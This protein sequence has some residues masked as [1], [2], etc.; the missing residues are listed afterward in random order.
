MTS[1]TGSSVTA[2]RNPVVSMENLGKCGRGLVANASRHLTD[3]VVVRF[4]QGSS[5]LHSMGDQIAVN[6]LTDKFR[7]P[8]RESRSTHPNAP[9]QFLYCPGPIWPFMNQLKR[10]SDLAVA[11]R[12]Q[13]S[14]F[15][16]SKRIEPIAEDFHEKHLS[17]P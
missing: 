5:L 6:G 7:E 15:S 4:E 12:A 8:S 16:G 2:G 11:Q 14:T 3:G 10:L 9:P 1:H 17:H 13:P